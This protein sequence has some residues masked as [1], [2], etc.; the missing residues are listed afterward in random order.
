MDMRI[1]HTGELSIRASL[2]L[3]LL[4]LA[5]EPNNQGY[6]PSQPI[7]YSH[8]VHA[9]ALGIDC[10]YCHYGAE[11]GRY[12][13][14]PPAAICMNCHAHVAQDHPEVAKVRSALESETP[15]KWVR[16]HRVPDHVYFDHSVHVTAKVECQ[17]CHGPVESMGL[18][19]QFST[20]SMGW[21]VNCH[22][23]NSKEVLPEGLPA[24]AIA[25]TDCAKCHR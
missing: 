18:V 22:R 13:G 3:A 19:R 17:T 5:C 8:A 23:D 14:I 25:L 21:C 9:G 1:Q 16:V 11:R 7:R 12:A 4:A 20:L 15:I 10:Q 24:R 6:T 2:S